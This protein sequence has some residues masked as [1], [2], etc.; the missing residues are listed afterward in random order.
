MIM[1]YVCIFVFALYLFH[2]W[3]IAPDGC[4]WND[5]KNIILTATIIVSVLVNLINNS[6]IHA[7]TQRKIGNYDQEEVSLYI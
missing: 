5:K 6:L 7:K 3:Y 2:R 1:E 4:F